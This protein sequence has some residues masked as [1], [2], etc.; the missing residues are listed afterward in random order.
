M[1]RCHTAL[2]FAAATAL[3][4][5]VGCRDAVAPTELSLVSTRLAAA[6]G[7]SD[8][9]HACQKGG[10]LELFR[11]DGTGFDNTG[12][13]VSYAAH[14]GVLARRLTATFTDV[15]FGACNSLTWGVEIDGVQQDLESFPGG[16]GAAD[17]SDQTVTY[18]STQTSR[19]YLRDN[20]CG[21]TYFEDGLHARVMG[22]NP[23]RIA[24]TDSGGF[25]ESD[26]SL[27]RPPGPGPD[28]G[29]LNVTRTIS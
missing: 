12:A 3:L 11:T 21:D 16:C 10:Y 13:C 24:I 29:N 14:G 26:P 8:A 2:S 1:Q 23:A 18:L 20:T 6:G 7:N 15:S 28:G 9:A 5:V 4:F 17:G 22:T 19:V 27:P 25:C